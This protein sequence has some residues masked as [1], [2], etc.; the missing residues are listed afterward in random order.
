MPPMKT[1]PNGELWVKACAEHGI[2]LLP[3]CVGMNSTEYKGRP[4]CIYDGW[5]HIGCPT[6]ALR[7][8]LVTHLAEARNAGAEVRARSTVTRVLTN[9]EGRRAT[10][11]EYYDA[12]KERHVQEAAVVVL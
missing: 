11:V 6:G 8:P 7:N 3:A 10:G 4:A 5:C 1:F 2:R 12:R 9:K